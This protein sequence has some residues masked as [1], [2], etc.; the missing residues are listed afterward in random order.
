MGAPP[1]VRHGWRRSFD[2]V[3]DLGARPR[4]PE[5]VDGTALHGIPLGG[6]GTGSF[7]RDWRGTF[8]GRSQSPGIVDTTPLAADCFAMAQRTAGGLASAEVLSPR[9][10]SAPG[11]A[12]WAFPRR[13]P[14]GEYRA[15]FPK[16]VFRYAAAPGRPVAATCEQFSPV[17]PHRVDLA[18]LPAAVFRWSLQNPSEEPVEVGILLSFTNPL[19][20]AAHYGRRASTE[21]GR[22]VEFGAPGRPMSAAI[23]VADT[24]EVAASHHACFFTEEDGRRVWEPFAS[25]ARLSGD[26]AWWAAGVPPSEGRP[27]TT[28]GAV[29]GTVTVPPGST[30]TMTFSLA[31]DLP[32]VT[33]GSGRTH[34]RRHTEW[35]GDA[36]RNA[37]AMAVEALR[38]ADEWSATIDT[39]HEAHFA[40][41]RPPELTSM[42]LNEL[43][44]LVEGWPVWTTGSVDGRVGPF[45]GLIEC[46]DY[47]HYDTLDLW[48]YGSWA[49][50][51]LWP[52]AARL[53]AAEYA[54]A[55]LAHDPLPRRSSDGA[56]FPTNRAGIAPHDLGSPR[57]DPGALVNS[58]VYRDPT[59]WKDLNAHFV[60]VARRDSADDPALAAEIFP[61]VEAAIECL[62]AHDTDGD[63]MIEN[64][65]TPDQTFDNLP[66]SGV[67]AYC[68]GLWPA[69]LSA[70]AAMA[71]DLGR[72]EAAAGWSELAR[73]A[74]RVFRDVLWTGSHFR[75]DSGGS[76]GDAVFAEQLFGPW[77]AER[78]GLNPVVPPDMARD[79]LRRIVEENTT[80]AGLVTLSDREGDAPQATEVLV[81]I[82]L[83]VACQLA[84]WGLDDE[85]HRVWET[86]RRGIYDERGLWFRTP[87]AWEVAGPRFRAAHNLRP[88]VIW[89]MVGTDEANRVGN[90]IASTAPHPP[91]GGASRTAPR[92]RRAPRLG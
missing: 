16:A 87:S 36:G 86:I 55:V 85:A 82:N 78:I 6:I 22:V 57:E 28:A 14:D 29:C 54:R 21:R 63:G 38:R 37:P 3:A 26:D 17:I 83:S 15:L 62:A 12:G 47:P 72:T 48:S 24:A 9:P 69:A 91:S 46:L 19:P 74:G 50:H 2:A 44:M 40:A 39:W 11:L 70:G 90:A 35:Y 1:V 61:A 58:Y 92:D 34:R 30:R 71:A 32:L 73:A 52:D 65:G 66:M 41:D 84:W 53:V 59:R 80:D 8:H 49:L 68:G 20:T 18:T 13:P 7:G 45:F 4:D 60:L 10:V 81:G 88:L 27:V 67:S 89:A 79:A 77:Y 76:F 5:H 33:F 51:H 75:F 31:W 25:T 56:I 23:A 43:A 64:D 42:L